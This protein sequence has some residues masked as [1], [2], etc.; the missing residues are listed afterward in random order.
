[1][2]KC[3]MKPRDAISSAAI[4]PAAVLTSVSTS[5]SRMAGERP[6]PSDQELWPER[7]A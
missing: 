3:G 6:A 7:R 4:V 1:M 2:E 5:G